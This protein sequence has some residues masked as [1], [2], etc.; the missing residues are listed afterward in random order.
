MS[1][2][3]IR[4]GPISCYHQA[5]ICVSYKINRALSEA[6]E[7]TV[8]YVHA[9]L[10]LRKRDLAVFWL[11]FVGLTKL[12][13]TTIETKW[14]QLC[15]DIERGQVWIALPLSTEIKAELNALLKPDPKRADELRIKFESG[16]QDIIPRIWPNASCIGLLTSG[17]FKT[18]AELLK[19]KYFGQIPVFSSGYVGTECNYACQTFAIDNKFEDNYTP[20]ADEVFF[21]FI[22]LE[23]NEEYE[24]VVTNNRGLYRYRCGDVIQV[25]GFFNDLPLIDP[26]YRSGQILNVANEKLTETALAEGLNIAA[27]HLDISVIDYTGVEGPTFEEVMKIARNDEMQG[28]YDVVF[29]EITAKSGQP[30]I[31]KSHE[32]AKFDGG[33]IEAHEN[34]RAKR[35]QG[36]LHTMLVYQVKDGTFIKFRQ[37]VL[38]S[39]QLTSAMQFKQ[40]RSLAKH[41]H[42][43]FFLDNVYKD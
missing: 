31:L 30:R 34:Y 42:I 5:N 39:N 40:P 25:V 11:T 32:K 22:P 23:M 3:G 7:E 20:V 33:L 4:I 37:M 26:S 13:I 18:S 8:F 35:N 24:I 27:N 14:K 21:E 2:H 1:P 12:W 9:L 15:T 19:K 28:L 36:I 41:E 43:K 16:F 17:S 10:A 29:I 6:G 38:A